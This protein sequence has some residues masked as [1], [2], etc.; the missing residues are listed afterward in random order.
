MSERVYRGTEDRYKSP[1]PANGRTQSELLGGDV[2][3]NLGERG[4]ERAPE[5]RDTQESFPSSY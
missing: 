5:E 2:A 1:P 3:V 4:K